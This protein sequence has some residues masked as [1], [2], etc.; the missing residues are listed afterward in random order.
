MTRGYGGLGERQRDAQVPDRPVSVELLKPL[1]EQRGAQ[2][3]SRALFTDPHA[4]KPSALPIITS[5][6]LPKLLDPS[7]SGAKTRFNVYLARFIWTK[8]PVKASERL[9]NTDIADKVTEGCMDDGFTWLTAGLYQLLDE[10]TLS[11]NVGPKPPRLQ[12]DTTECF[13]LQCDADDGTKLQQ[14][15]STLVSVTAE[16]APTASCLRAL[17]AK[18][19]NY[20][21]AK[22]PTALTGLGLVEC[23]TTVSLADGT[24]ITKRIYKRHFDSDEPQPAGVSDEPP[25]GGVQP[26]SV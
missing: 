18:V 13:N 4:F 2:I 15:F 25:P 19:A 23:R 3:A 21:P 9:A 11:R 20:E 17:C 10:S 16:Q 26:P 24:R 14:W 7:E 12:S 1:C 22:I 6:F 8:D 5:N